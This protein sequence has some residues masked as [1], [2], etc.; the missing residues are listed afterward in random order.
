MKHKTLKPSQTR[1][2]E[3]RHK[4]KIKRN[5]YCVQVKIETKQVCW[6]FCEVRGGKFPIWGHSRGFCHKCW[7][8]QKTKP[9]KFLRTSSLK[10]VPGDMP[11]WRTPNRHVFKIQNEP[12]N[13]SQACW[14]ETRPSDWNPSRSQFVLSYSYYHPLPAPVDCLYSSVFSLQK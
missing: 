12:M 4:K 6:I 13:E 2:N 9:N 14:L 1:N 10:Y 8:S 11:P 3:L 7:D 5:I